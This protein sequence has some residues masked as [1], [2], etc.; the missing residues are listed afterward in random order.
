VSLSAYWS[1][2]SILSV[3]ALIMPTRFV[4][5]HCVRSTKEGV[6]SLGTWNY[7]GIPLAIKSSEGVS[8]SSSPIDG[9]GTS[10]NL[11]VDGRKGRNYVLSR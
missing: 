5:E 1:L 2:C 9:L 7:S 11:N 10:L 6:A 8:T 4:D 3:E